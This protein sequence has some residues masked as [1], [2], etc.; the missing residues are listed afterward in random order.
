MYHPFSTKQNTDRRIIIR[1]HHF[2]F[3]IVQIH[4]QLRSILMAE[5]VYLQFHNNMTFQDAVIEYEVGKEI[6][7]INQDT[8]LS[9][10]KAESMPHFQQEV[11]QVVK[12]GLLQVVFCY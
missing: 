1:L 2:R 6:I 7:L 8:F 4:I 11:L 3:E 9:G 12:N 10:F 5:L